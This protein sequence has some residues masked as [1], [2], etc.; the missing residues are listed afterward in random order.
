MHYDELTMRIAIG[1][2]DLR[3]VKNQQ[4]S[5]PVP[6]GQL[7]TMDVI[8]RLGS[9]SM[10]EL[11]LALRIDA[12]TATRAVDR[13]VESGLASRRRS[14]EDAR[15]VM[16]ELTREGRSL[17]RTLTAE[18]MEHMEAILERLT[19]KERERVAESLDLLLGAI[20][21][22]NGAARQPPEPA[23]RS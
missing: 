9:C 19:A 23:T 20:D 14:D 4:L 5:K 10:V 17:E 8:G 18:R 2:R 22:A 3:R 13:L 16:V 6:Q 7:D 12:S 15:T 11:S 21:A 1:W